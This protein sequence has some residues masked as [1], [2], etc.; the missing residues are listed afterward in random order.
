MTRILNR[1]EYV[2]RIESV[3]STAAATTGIQP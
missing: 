3:G 2:N 1:A